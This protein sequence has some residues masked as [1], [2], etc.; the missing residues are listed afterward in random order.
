MLY[1]SPS[2]NQVDGSPPFV[3][4]GARSICQP[5]PSEHCP[6]L[7]VVFDELVLDISL[8]DF[9]ARLHIDMYMYDLD[10]DKGRVD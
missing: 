1:E 10:S 6:E 7:L 4:T 5:R 3:H 8:W 9:D 2:G